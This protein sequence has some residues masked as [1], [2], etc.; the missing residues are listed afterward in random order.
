MCRAAPAPDPRRVRGLF[1]LA[2][3][4]AAAAEPHPTGASDIAQKKI[5]HRIPCTTQEVRE[6]K[7]QSK[8]RTLLTEIAKQMKR[9]EWALRRKAGILGIGLGHRRYHP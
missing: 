7:A 6:L 9:T 3:A 4:V 8:A 5:G 1:Q 2:R